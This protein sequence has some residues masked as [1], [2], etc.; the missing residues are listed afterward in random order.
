MAVSFVLEQLESKRGRF[1]VKYQVS[2]QLSLEENIC[3]SL[4]F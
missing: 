3:Q 4:Q 2:A 1:L